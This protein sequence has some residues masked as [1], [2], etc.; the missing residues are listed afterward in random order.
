VAPIRPNRS[1]RWSRYNRLIF[2][3]DLGQALLEE[4]TGEERPDFLRHGKSWYLLPNPLFDEGAPEEVVEHLLRA[5]RGGTQAETR[6]WFTGR[7]REVNTVVSWVRSSEP[8]VRVVTGSAGLG[9]SA[10]VGRVVCLS[11][12]GERARLIRAGHAGGHD[13]P[14]EG[15]VTAHVHARGLTVDRIADILDGQ[16]IRAG[17]L[18]GHEAGRRNASELVGAVQRAVQEGKQPPVVVIDGLDEARSQTFAIAEDLIVRLAP[19]AVV[20]VSTRPQQRQDGTRLLDVF[21]ADE[22]LDLDTPASQ[23]SG[24]DAIREY[25]V[26]RLRGASSEMDPV[27]IARHVLGDS[28]PDQP[29]LLAR[30]ITDQ[31]LASPVSTSE[32]DWQQHIARSTEEALDADITRIEPHPSRPDAVRLAR[33]MLTALTWSLGAG[34]PEDEWLT[35]ASATMDGALN[36]D[37]IS[38]VLDQLGRYVIQDGEAG[39][40]VY[41]LAHQSL[42]DHLRPPYRPTGDAPFDPAATP[43]CSALL[44]RYSHLLNQGLEADAPTYL[45]QWPPARSLTAPRRGDDG[46]RQWHQLRKPLRCTGVW[47]QRTPP[48]YPTLPQ[49]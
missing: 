7:T 38:W 49:P 32:P 14:G 31:L 34:F 17:T 44:N 48:T 21:G 3:E 40:A 11:N 36:R 10:V 42:T 26:A 47:P 19:F 13:D 23:Q 8:G 30:V 43:V 5:A 20:V 24:R 9:K 16:L 39:V 35:V 33:L 12:P 4:W 18:R 37:D 46:R 29:F 41:R 45:S 15:S 27:L 22:V 6:S 25:M 1:R 28:V 2:G